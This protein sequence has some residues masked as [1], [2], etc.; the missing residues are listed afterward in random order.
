MAR[1]AAPTAPRFEHRTDDG[2]V[3]AVHTPTPRL[4]WIIPDAEAGFA[5]A[6]YEIEVTPEDGESQ[7]FP[8]ESTEQ[9]LVPWPAK[10]IASRQT[11][12]VR[13]RVC[14]GAGG[15]TAW[16]EPSVAE[17]GLYA[18]SDWTARFISPR[19]LGGLDAPAPVLRGTV[20]VP[21]DV[22]RARLYVTAYGLHRVSVNG[23]AASDDLLAPGWTSYDHR[24]RYRAYD[25]AHLVGRGEN[26]VDAVLGNGWYRGRLGFGGRRALYGDRLALLAQL[27]ITTVD[28]RVHVLATDGSWTAGESNV[29]ADDLYDGQHTDLRRPSRPESTPDAVDIL[30]A[31]LGRLVAPEGPPGADHTAASGHCGD[32]LAV[33]ADAGRL[34]TEPRRLGAPTGTRC[35]RRP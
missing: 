30:G 31:E 18:E 33:W 16:S 20:V 21:G 14:D 35:G 11:V 34:R 27:E 29:L 15:W 1:A 9:V 32:P 28:G 17:G 24:L 3:L 12:S 5:A 8:V 22:T 7:T 6:A 26:T 2:P 23:R 25:V 13:I 19:T 10:T 4:S